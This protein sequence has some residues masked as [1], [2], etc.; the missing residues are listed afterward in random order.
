MEPYLDALIDSLDRRFSNLDLLSTF[1]VLGPQGSWK[2]VKPDL[3]LWEISD[4]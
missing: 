4:R 3:A 2:S 1:H